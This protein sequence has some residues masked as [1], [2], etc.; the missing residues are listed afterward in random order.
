M[1]IIKISQNSPNNPLNGKSKHSARN[2]IYNLI[3]N[4]TKGIF[5]DN[6]WENVN[7]IW[8]KLDQNNIANNIT[9]TQYNHDE[10]GQ[11]IGKTW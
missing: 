2:Y 4:L 10:K 11:S 7:N 1:R 3:G 6:S 9:K 8:N 5:S